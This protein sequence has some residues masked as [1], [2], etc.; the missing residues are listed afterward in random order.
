MSDNLSNRE[1]AAFYFGAFCTILPGMIAAGFMPDWNIFP[2]T[3]WIALATIGAAVAG[4]IA[5]P[6]QWFLAMLAGGISGGGTVLGIVL[7]V[8][9]RMQLIPTGTFLRL[10]L[11][12]GAIFGAI[13]GMILWSKWFVR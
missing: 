3:T 2:A 8:Y 7:Y 6:R 10:E 5:K 11:A 4:V 12:I 13:P 9:L 1:T